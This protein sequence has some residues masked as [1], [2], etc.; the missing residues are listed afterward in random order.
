[1]HD[2]QQVINAVYAAAESLGMAGWTLLAKAKLTDLVKDRHAPYAGPPIDQ[3]PNCTAQEKQLIAAAL[4]PPTTPSGE[5]GA[6]VGSAEPRKPL[7]GKGFYIWK[8]AD[9]EGGNAAAIAAKAQA[10]GLSHVLI[11][12]AHGPEPYRYNITTANDRVGPLVL[13]LRALGGD[14]QVWGWQYTFGEQPEG[15]AHI[16]AALVQQYR[17]DGFVINAEKEYKRQGAASL[18]ARYTSTLRQDLQAAGLSDLPVALSTYR[19]P[20]YHGEFPWSTFLAVCTLMMPQVYWVT[21]GTPDPA[22]NLQR[23]LQE[24]RALGWT[25]P[26]VPTG[27]AYDEWQY[28]DDGSRWL[29]STK[30]EQIEAFLP[31]AKAADLPAANFWCWDQAGQA[32]WDAIAAFGW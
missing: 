25:G 17:L 32:R 27:A 13:A 29:W 20:S 22:A 6:P 4:P 15:D 3:L 21:R 28:E 11:K 8:V 19:Y 30:P 31:A 9:C 1:M 10:A 5:G 14:F 18:A 16:A 23:C 26:I 24:Y 12:I 7:Q 2:N